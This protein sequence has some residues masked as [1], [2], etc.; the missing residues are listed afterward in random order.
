MNPIRKT[1]SL[2]PVCLKKLDADII[3]DGG[4]LYM[5]KGCLE[6]GRFK[7]VVWRDKAE[8]Y[9]E[10]IRMAGKQLAGKVSNPNP[11]SKGCPWDCGYC[12]D[13]RQDLCSAALMVTARC[14]LDCPI[15]FTHEKYENGYHPSLKTLKARVMKY[16]D[17]TKT[18][19]PIEL[20]GGE[21]TLRDDLPELASYAKSIGFDYIQLNTN[22]IRIAEDFA[23]LE[24]LKASGVTTIYLGFDG[25]SDQTYHHTC[26]SQLVEKKRKAVEN[27]EIARI[28]VVLVP[29]IVPGKN[30]NELGKIIEYA[31]D[32]TPAVKGVFI[33]PISY[34]GRFPH[35][36]ED[37]DR[38]TIPE[39]LDRI[40]TQ[41][42]GRVKRSHFQPPV[43]E[44]PTCSFHGFFLI[45]NGRFYPMTR[46]KPRATEPN[47]AARIRRITKS[48]WT[49]NEQSYLTIGGMAFQ[50][51]WN[52]DLE[53]VRRCSIGILSEKNGI[54]PLCVKYL[55]NQTG[56]RL[57]PGIA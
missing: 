47:A 31:K 46:L 49:Y 21:P 43:C 40:E 19:Y 23:Y 56:D 54:V 17:I 42:N 29:V 3:E 20:C 39:I 27:C 55:T 28:A 57:Y 37:V 30:D 32:H 44:H 53:R 11:S 16:L 14:N 7:T 5:I 52:I 13:H 8:S 48:T 24:K 35:P 33:Q 45:K 22:G 2:C 51:V 25:F 6:H 41:S 9:L 1:E 4:T 50:D 36:P 38:I 26:G 34:F 15:C 18:P 10:W 12:A